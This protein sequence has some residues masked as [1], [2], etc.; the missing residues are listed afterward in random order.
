V[1]SFGAVSAAGCSGCGGEQGVCEGGER[2]E[3]DELRRVEAV[4]GQR[5]EDPLRFAVAFRRCS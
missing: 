2:F 5:G 3:D 1:V 4:A